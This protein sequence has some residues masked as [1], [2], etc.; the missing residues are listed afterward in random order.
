MSVQSPLW[1]TLVVILAL[2]WV[3]GLLTT[4][5][6]KFQ[7]LSPTTTMK[8]SRTVTPYTSAT[9]ILTRRGETCEIH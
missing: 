9:R 3:A 6:K 2:G 1:L 4:R 8:S 5:S 7:Q